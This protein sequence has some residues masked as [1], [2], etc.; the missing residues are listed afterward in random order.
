MLPTLGRNRLFFSNPISQLQREFDRFFSGVG[1][2]GGPEGSDLVATY[3]VDVREDDGHIFVDAELPGFEK[4]DVNISLEDGV[5]VLEAERSEEDTKEGT[6]H[7][8]ERTHRRVYRSFTL[9]TAVDDHKVDAKLADGV[10]KIVLNKQE[11]VK[12]RRI[13]VK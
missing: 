3:P 9:P 12:P 10:L 4:K 8:N 5:L 2:E 11:E 1:T 7:L 13:E 6:V